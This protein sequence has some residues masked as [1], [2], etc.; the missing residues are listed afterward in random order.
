MYKILIYVIGLYFLYKFVF[1]F[2]IPVGKMTTQIK[3]N[4]EEINR[5]Q[6]KPN[7][8]RSKPPMNSQNFNYNSE[9]YIDFEEVSS[10]K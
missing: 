3:K 9:E 10:K 7:Q 5:Q 8:P 6:N 1:N 2:V 4:V